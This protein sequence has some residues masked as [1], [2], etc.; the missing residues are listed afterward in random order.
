M[1]DVMEMLPKIEAS[2][3]DAVNPVIFID[4]KEFPNIMSAITPRHALMKFNED[5]G[6]YFYGVRGGLN[7]RGRG[8]IESM[9]PN[10]EV[11][12]YGTYE[13]STDAII[14]YSNGDDEEKDPTYKNISRR[15]DNIENLERIKFKLENYFDDMEDYFSKLKFTFDGDKYFRESDKVIRIKIKN[16]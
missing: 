11:A 6:T 12:E 1:G 4:L 3:A 15:R 8:E 7:C 16:E 9:F 10:D 13:Y 5:N 2:Y 14:L